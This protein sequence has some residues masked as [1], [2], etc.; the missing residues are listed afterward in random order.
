[1]RM[2]CASISRTS[3]A[4]GPFVTSMRQRRRR[5]LVAR[6][7]T[8][9]T[10]VPERRSSTAIRWG[11]LTRQASGFR[12]QAPGQIGYLRHMV[13]TDLVRLSEMDTAWTVDGAGARLAAVRRAGRA[14]RD[15]ILAGG[16]ARC[17]RTADL[18]TF[19]YPTKYGFAG[20][21]RSIAPYLMM[22]NR[23]QL[24]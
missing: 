6:P 17:V 18:A 8:Y 23:M 21:A 10:Q 14:L 12:P 19:P 1:M 4:S 9:V 13:P 11:T 2:T 20:A 15:R 3:P 7:P 5:A 16:T 24:V 22:R